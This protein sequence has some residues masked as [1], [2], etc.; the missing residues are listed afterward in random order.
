VLV[1]G[2]CLVPDDRSL[3]AHAHSVMVR[4]RHAHGIIRS[5][6][7]SAARAMPGVLAIYTGADLVAAGYDTLKCIVPFKNRDGSDMR[8]PPRVPMP[9]DKVRYV[10]DPIACVIAET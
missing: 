7:T 6:E 4:S 5:I 8:K 3:P 10:G 9:T 2:Q 1:R